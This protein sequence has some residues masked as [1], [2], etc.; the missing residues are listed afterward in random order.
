MVGKD[1]A[2]AA[3]KRYFIMKKNAVVIGYGGMGG[4]HVDHLLKS[5]VCNLLGVYDIKPERNEL[6]RSRGVFAYDSLEQVLA[7]ERVD[8]CTV[9]I[10]NDSHKSVCIACLE[11]GKNVICEKPVMLSARRILRDVIAV[12][13][14][15]AASVSTVHQNRRFDVD[16]LAMK[17]IKECGELG[18]IIQYRVP[19]PRLARHSRATGEA[20]SEHGGGMLYDWGIHLI[21]QLLQLFPGKVEHVYLAP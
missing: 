7:D 6:A 4:W 3:V 12:A 21:D 16:F 19:H 18:E 11:A 10:P 5:D 15:A 20:S 1:A 17:Q 14:Q 13:D 2:R 9:A 8:M